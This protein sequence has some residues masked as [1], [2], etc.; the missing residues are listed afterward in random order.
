[1]SK[2][3]IIANP[4]SGKD[5]RRLVAY[6]SVTDNTE[7]TNLMRRIILGIDS[8]GVD[9]ILI[10]P[11]YYNLGLRA[12]DGMGTERIRAKVPIVDMAID[13]TARDTTLAAERM[14]EEGVGCIVT[15]G[16]DGTNR[17]VAKGKQDVPLVPISTG[18]NNVFPVMTESTS[19]GIAAGIIAR[20]ILNGNET[21]KNHK[22]L[23]VTKNGTEID[24]ALVDAVVLDQLFIGSRAIWKLAEVRQIICTQA[25]PN[26]IGMTCIG[27]NL[28][29][30]GPDDKHGLH[31]KL[32]SG[33]LKVRAAVLPGLV[34]EVEVAGL[35]TL[36]MGEEVDVLC[37][38]SVIALDGEREITVTAADQVKIRLQEDGPRVVDIE[39]TIRAAVAKGGD[40]DNSTTIGYGSSRC[41]YH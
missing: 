8:T 29:P 4:A 32:G 39:G 36:E 9:E 21:I 10:M 6:A 15:L 27:G 33:N 34:T 1:V 2:V 5:I 22:R 20:N 38:P 24:M 7:K 19:A 3:G 17:D 37:K 14:G 30:V 18:T 26:N 13:Y 40:R 23:V 12:L 16:G 35:E 31:I 41:L 11:D 28:Q 25:E